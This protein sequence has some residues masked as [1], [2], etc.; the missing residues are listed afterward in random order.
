MTHILL[1]M[2]DTE[3]FRVVEQHQR[4]SRD[5]TRSVIDRILARGADIVAESGA[6]STGVLEVAI[7]DNVVWLVKFL[8]KREANP[9]RANY[10][11]MTPLHE[12]A[13]FVCD[14]TLLRLLLKKRGNVE[15]MNN[16]G[17]TPLFLAVSVRW[18]EGVKILLAHGADPRAVDG[19]GMKLL[20]LASG[21]FPTH[22]NT[23]QVLLDLDVIDINKKDDV[24]NSALHRALLSLDATGEIYQQIVT[25]LTRYG[26]DLT[27]K[28][29]DGLTPEHLTSIFSGGISGCRL[30]P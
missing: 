3:L 28:N 17:E 21:F 1:L 14:K 8:L 13:E 4:E 5:F 22:V 2:A 10:V 27:I 20:H 11:N 16:Y 29:H 18:V 12:V 6:N 26:A 7:E 23:L 19:I 9:N 25:M 15:A 24:G 30:C